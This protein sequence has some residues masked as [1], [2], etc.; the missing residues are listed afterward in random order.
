MS[1]ERAEER[2]RLAERQVAILAKSKGERLFEGAWLAFA[3]WCIGYLLVKGLLVSLGV[4]KTIASPVAVVLCMLFLTMC[5][6]FILI[7]FVARKI[8]AHELNQ[9]KI[10]LSQFRQM[11]PVS[12]TSGGTSGSGGYSNYKKNTAV[13]TG[14]EFA[15]QV[16]AEGKAQS[17]EVKKATNY[18]R[19]GRR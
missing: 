2:V 18:I 14:K 16:K 9:S 6:S 15:A 10:Y 5:G 8:A 7:R 3:V 4:L 1:L 19:S 12:Y 17:S 13:M 11:S